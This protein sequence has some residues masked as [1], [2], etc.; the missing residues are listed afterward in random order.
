[1][2]GPQPQ[3]GC[4]CG[5][6]YRAFLDFVWSRPGLQHFTVDCDF[7]CGVIVKG[8]GRVPDGLI[9]QLDPQEREAIAAGWLALG[10]NSEAAFDYL[11]RNKVPLLN[12]ISAQDFG[13]VFG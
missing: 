6:T 3:P 7:G 13:A 11:Q 1:M 4:W 8:E 2:A 10:D 5:W 12:L 9:P